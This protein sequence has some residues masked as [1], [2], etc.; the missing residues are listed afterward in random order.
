VALEVGGSSPLGHPNHR[1]TPAAL[2]MASRKSLRLPPS[3][4]RQYWVFHIWSFPLSSLTTLLTDEP[5]ETI[6]LDAT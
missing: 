2:S 5:N 1:V 3:Y 6:N 4:R